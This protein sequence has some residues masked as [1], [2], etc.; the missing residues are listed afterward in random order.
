MKYL[1]LFSL[2]WSA[3]VVIGSLRFNII[4]RIYQKCKFMQPQPRSESGMKYS[5][6]LGLIWYVAQ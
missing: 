1:V 6:I 4:F 5:E 3:A 2:M